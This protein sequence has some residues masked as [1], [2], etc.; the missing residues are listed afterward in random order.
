MAMGAGW[1][2]EHPAPQGAEAV[3]MA[4]SFP[5]SFAALLASPDL[6]GAQARVSMGEGG[7]LHVRLDGADSVH[8]LEELMTSARQ[9]RAQ[10]S[11][12]N[13]RAALKAESAAADAEATALA[14]SLGSLEAQ[15]D[16]I[17]AT[18][19]LSNDTEQSRVVEEARSK[20]F[21][22]QSKESELLAKYQESSPIVQAVQDERHQTEAMIRQFDTPLPARSRSGINPVRQSLELEAMKT[23]TALASAR[24]KARNLSQRLAELDRAGSDDITVIERPHL[25]PDGIAPSM[26][27]GVAA[28]VGLGF[29]SMVA[30]L[31]ERWSARFATPSEVERHLDLPVLTSIPRE[32]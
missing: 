19:Q 21:E 6:T 8:S 3:L 10:D 20:L 7:L 26:I 23:R 14:E 17:P 32:G 4:G 2:F 9:H 28:V 18:I 31:A 15:R 22:L 24:S 12:R 25:H 5:D 11:W 30:A 16:A 29:A 13:R 1:V 27:M